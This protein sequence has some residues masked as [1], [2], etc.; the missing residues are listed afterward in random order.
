MKHSGGKNLTELAIPIGL[1]LAEKAVSTLG[2]Q[3]KKSI[4]K[5]TKSPT[6]K[7][8]NTRVKRVS[9]LKGGSSGSGEPFNASNVTDLNTICNFEGTSAN[10]NAATN[11]NAGSNVGSNV[12]SNTGSLEGGGS[13]KK[14]APKKKAVQ[15]KSAPKKKA[16]SKKSAPKKKGIPKKQSSKK[17]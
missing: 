15:K 4:K 11:T 8:L 3:Q 12:G 16:V 14:S 5:S 10:T 17:I 6:N 9:A 7:N 13:K 2:K 1:I